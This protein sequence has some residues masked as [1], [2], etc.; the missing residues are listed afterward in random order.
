MPKI[1]VNKVAEIL[2]KNQLEPKLLRQIVEEM[3]LLTQPEADEEKPPA[4]KKQYVILVSDPENRLPK[5]D[6]VGWVLEIPE[7][8]SVVTATERI[9]RAVYDFNASKKGR[10]MPANTVGEAMEHVP[11]KFFK[12]AELWVKTREP[13]LI[14]KTDNSIPRDE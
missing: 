4:I 11:A 10:L 9:N 7:S 2:K 12:E 3:N 13:V 8:E 5:S 14:I 1:E 6:F